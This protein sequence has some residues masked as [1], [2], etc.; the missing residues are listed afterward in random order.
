MAAGNLPN[1]REGWGGRLEEKQVMLWTLPRRNKLLRLKKLKAL[2]V[3]MG[4][5]SKRLRSTEVEHGD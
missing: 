3:T 5:L 2:T 1:D 4:P